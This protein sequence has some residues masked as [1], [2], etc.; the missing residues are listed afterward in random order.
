MDVPKQVQDKLSQFQ[1]IQNQIQMVSMQKQQLMMQ[2]ADLD[3]AKS[4]VEPLTQGKV[5]RLVGPILI[6]TTKD[7][8]LKYVT[9]EHESADT[10]VKVLERQEKKLVDKMNEMRQ[11]LTSMLQP[12]GGN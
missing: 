9:D 4:E 1:N 6:E 2:T 8:A 10:K 5:Y 11:E 12:P 3:N 7:A